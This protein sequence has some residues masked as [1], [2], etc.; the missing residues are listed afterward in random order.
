[1]N[2]ILLP[3]YKINILAPDPERVDRNI[4]KFYS[5]V[6][7]D[8]IL[9]KVNIIK[10]GYY[11]KNIL[12]NIVPTQIYDKYQSICSAYSSMD[13]ELNINAFCFSKAK[14]DLFFAQ[15]YKILEKNT[16]IFYLYIISSSNEENYIFNIIKY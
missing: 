5:D 4:Y 9:E 15:R 10:S 13:S 8:I 6:D 3:L 12:F 2:D 14:Q 1:M 7:Y 11:L 16:C